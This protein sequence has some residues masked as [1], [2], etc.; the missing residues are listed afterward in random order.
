[1]TQAMT[2]TMPQT[3][4]QTMT[5]GAD[6]RQG[7]FP[8]ADPNRFHRPKFWFCLFLLVL[9]LA[10]ILI[11]NWIAFFPH[12]FATPGSAK[13]MQI[14]VLLFD[15]VLLFML[16]MPFLF[17]LSGHRKNNQSLNTNAIRLSNRRL[18][19]KIAYSFHNLLLAGYFLLITVIFLLFF[20]FC[21]LVGFKWFLDFKHYMGMLT[22]YYLIFGIP[23]GIKNIDRFLLRIIMNIFNNFYIRSYISALQ[24]YIN[25]GS[26]KKLYTLGNITFS[27]RLFRSSSFIRWKYIFIVLLLAI[28]NPFILYFLF[29]KIV[30]LGFIQHDSNILYP[31]LDAVILFGCVYG[32]ALC[33]D[34][35]SCCNA[36]NKNPHKTKLF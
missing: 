21:E 20:Y 35:V 23:V 28:L 27:D 36:S 30:Y 32:S 24:F 16:A 4:P 13:Q 9:L 15:S 29:N 26:H 11:V 18:P 8:K 25:S 2:Q 3:M 14:F 5:Q 34:H 6:S 19:N 1:M 7:L 33:L 22:V 10:P 12:A 17:S 31:I